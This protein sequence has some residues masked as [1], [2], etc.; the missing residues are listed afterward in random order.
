MIDKLGKP[1]I[2]KEMKVAT[3]V[4]KQLSDKSMSSL[5]E[6]IV[7][8]ITNVDNSYER[9]AYLKKRKIGMENVC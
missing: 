3:R 4:Y 9:L 6:A 5:W 7:E 1:I 8:F 2:S